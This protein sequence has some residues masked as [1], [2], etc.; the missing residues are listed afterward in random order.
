MKKGFVFI[1]TLTVLMVLVTVLLSVF[2]T[3]QSLTTNINQR[4][5]YD[6]IDDIYK[7]N[8]LRDSVDI[9]YIEDEGESFVVI[10]ES[11]CQDYFKAD[12]CDYLMDDLD[13]EKIYINFDT[14]EEIINNPYFDHDNSLREYMKTIE[15]SSVN[16]IGRDEEMYKRMIIVK[17][18]RGEKAYYASLDI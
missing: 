16:A 10:D 1:E 6:N 14:V 17:F 18:K 7:V 9:D 3:Y 15:T 5:T 11:N 8:I 4:E 12:M 2:L 13:A